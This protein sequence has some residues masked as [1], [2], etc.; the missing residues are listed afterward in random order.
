MKN[1]IFLLGLI[2]SI[3]GFLLMFLSLMGKMKKVEGGAM[4]FIGP[5]PIIAASSE[6]VVMFMLLISFLMI[7]STL[8]MF[9]MG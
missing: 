5:F 6:R 8:L 9:F 1:H 3:T 2:L 7:L 4:V